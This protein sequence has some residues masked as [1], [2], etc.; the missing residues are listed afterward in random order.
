MQ[1]AMYHCSMFDRRRRPET[2][3]LYRCSDISGGPE[4]SA[5][6]D[7]WGPTEVREEAVYV[8]TR[9]AAQLV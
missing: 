5:D 3:P 1:L 7:D 2:S 6:D 4:T 8:G 9:T